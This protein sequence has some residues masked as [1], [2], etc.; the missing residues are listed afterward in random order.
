MSYVGRSDAERRRMLDAI[1]VER[2]EQLLADVPADLRWRGRPDVPGP[3]SEIELRAHFESLAGDNDAAR[4]VPSFLGGGM[5]DHYVPAALPR[6]ILRSEFLTCYTPYQ[7]EVA[8]GTLTVIFEFQSMIA[9]L[10]G[11]DVANA[12]LYDGASAIAEACGLARAHSGRGRVVVAAGVHPTYLQVLRTILGPENVEEINSADGAADP[13]RTA[14][15]LGADVA[16]LVV[17]YPNFFGI[18][19]DALPALAEKAHAAGALVIASAEPL[20]LALLTPPGEWGADICAGEGQ[21][22]GVPIS[23]GGP[24]LGFLAARKE[25][26]RRLP[27]RIA[28][29]TVDDKGRRGFVLTLQTREQHIRREKATSNICTNQ[30]L[31]ALAATIYMSL[32]G[33]EGLREV[34]NLCFQKTHYAAARAE[35]VAGLRPV[36]ARPF[37]REFALHLPVPASEACRLGRERGVLVGV[38]LGRF[39]SA[40]GNHLLVA[41][42]EKRTQAEIDRW[43]ACLAEVAGTRSAEAAGVGR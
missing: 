37:F 43:A 40:W 24:A 36:Y 18:V 7:P 16:A 12:S 23:F 39:S 9:E 31:L 38:D 8:Q 32:L 29:E 17:A 2:F 34:A 26:V 5:Y 33:K 13:E 25:L 15:A 22:L 6:L 11:L 19:D 28:G 30:G 10:T 27:G 21:P 4:G 41:V 35:A 14:N 3:L 42:T 20:S 1:G